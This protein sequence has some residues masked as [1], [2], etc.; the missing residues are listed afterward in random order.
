MIDLSFSTGQKLSVDRPARNTK[1]RNEKMATATK[2][3]GRL[4]YLPLLYL[5][6]ALLI[7]IAVHEGSVG[8]KK[9]KRVKKPCESSVVMF[10][11]EHG[12]ANEEGIHSFHQHSKDAVTTVAVQHDS[13][14]SVEN[15]EILGGTNTYQFEVLHDQNIPGLFHLHRQSMLGADSSTATHHNIVMEHHYTFTSCN[16]ILAIL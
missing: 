8:A 15:N 5:I 6:R 14:Q 4:Y 7:I 3:G 2:R 9:H 13:F 11:G 10:H 1:G 12:G 16:D